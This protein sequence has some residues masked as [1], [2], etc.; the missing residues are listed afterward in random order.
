MIRD[1]IAIFDAV[2]GAQSDQEKADREAELLD[3]VRAEIRD[4]YDDPKYPRRRRTFGAIRQRLAIYDNDP[5]TLTKILFAMN[6]RRVKGDG[7]TALWE[8]P[9]QV[10]GAETPAPPRKPM[11]WQT[12][13]A[14]IA[15]GAVVVLGALNFNTVRGWFAGSGPAT[16]AECLAAANGNMRRISECERLFPSP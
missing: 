10:E 15:I 13:A 5:D 6:A 7:D 12:L 11:R 16:K 2:L 14:I 8:L 9:R 1:L 3:A 4:L